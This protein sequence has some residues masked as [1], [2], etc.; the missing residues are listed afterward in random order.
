MIYH[1][2]T[3]Q[4]GTYHVEKGIVCQDAHSFKLIN[5]HFAIA[6]VADG[7]GSE[8]HSDIASQT[9]VKISVE[10]CANSIQ[11]NDTEEKILSIIKESFSKSL[12][13]INIIATSNNDDIDQYD[14]TLVVVVYINGN[15]YFGNAGDSGVVVLNKN[16]KYEA[17]TT[18]QRDEDG[19]V[20]PLWFGEEK[21]VFGKKENVAS[22]FMATDG[23]YET[24]FPFLLKG[25]D[26]PLYVALAHYMMS[27]ECVGFTSQPAEDIQ[28]KME[29][30]I[31]N[32]P[33]NQ[34]NDDKTV[35]VMYD[36]NI[37]PEKL[38]D[39]YY[40]SPDWVELKKKHDEEY[41]RLA[42]PNM[43]KKDNKE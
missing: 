34:V 21:W 11:E 33:G 32:I 13:E 12:E 30:F 24:L 9:A 5:E 25:T 28:Q 29:D 4:Q 27:D 40:K 26:D 10:H 31:A 19:H 23:M 20:F 39:D 16:G 14:T 3:T 18:Q 22:V 1:Y 6:A 17:L 43:Y 41:R 38:E 37:I 2:G 42:Y 7:L 36:S 15:V 8:S 35:L